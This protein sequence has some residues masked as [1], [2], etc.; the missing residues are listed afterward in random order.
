MSI[1]AKAKAKAAAAPASAKK[2][3]TTWVVTDAAL[4]EAIK[5][6]VELEAKAKVNATAQTR[7]KTAL[8]RYAEEHFVQDYV[9]EEKLPEAP[10][11]IANQAG[12]SVN[13]VFQDRSGQYG[14]S[15]EQEKDLKELLGEDKVNEILYEETR[16]AFNRVIMGIPG[17]MD[18]LA[19]HLEA[20]RD[21]LL[22]S[23]VLTPEQ[24]DELIDVQAKRTVRSGVLDTLTQVCGR[25]STR[26]RDFLRYIG[27]CAVRY[28]KP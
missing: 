9:R 26:L 11:L 10:M 6:L 17:V 13:F 21:E 25:D 1:F 18:C 22:Q 19:K 23:K 28:I 15:P 16:F 3:S 12:D 20:C 5:E 4:S 8:L 24:A 2:K 14:V 27:S 7:L